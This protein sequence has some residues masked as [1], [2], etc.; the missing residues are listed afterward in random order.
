MLVEL[1]NR[2]HSAQSDD[3]FKVVADGFAMVT[4][5]FG[6]SLH[7]MVTHRYGSFVIRRFLSI[8]CG[9]DVRS[10]VSKSD[11]IQE[12]PSRTGGLAGKLQ[13]VDGN[14]GQQSVPYPELLE[15]ITE[16]VLSEDWTG[17]EMLALQC[18]SH[19]SPCLQ[20]LIRACSFDEGIT[21]RLVLQVLGASSIDSLPVEKLRSLLLDKSGSHLMEVI[22][23]VA[24]DDVYQKLTT[25]L[26]KGH[27]LPLAQHPCANFAVQAAIIALRK[28][29]QLKRMVEDLRPHI[30]SLLK[31]RRSGVV[32][33]LLATAV[34]LGAQ[35][36][37]LASLLWNAVGKNGN[38]PLEVLLTLDSHASLNKKNS[39]AKLST[40]GCAM[41]STIFSFPTSAMKQYS[42]ALSQLDPAQLTVIARDP[43]GCR[44]IESFMYNASTKKQNHVLDSLTRSW[45]EIALTGSGARFVECCFDIA[46]A[47][48]KEIIT[49]EL[50]SAQQKLLLTHR[51]PVLLQKCSV[52]AYKKGGDVKLEMR[53]GA[54][55][56]KN[57]FEELFAGI[58]EEGP[59]EKRIKHNNE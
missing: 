33:A 55:A 24:P 52:L 10:G 40:L 44:V 25:A 45:G 32:A 36:E 3:D 7:D 38:H 34:K 16:V 42:D 1:S 46:D 43:G 59:Q 37:E 35:E 21:K 48:R 53:R 23:A 13:K 28:P 14:V 18:D 39:G 19:A 50:A 29:A 49:S 27:L 31:G 17:P 58:D 8:L 11:G 30:G 47:S 15:E 22:F 51:G 2:A 5:I 12:K 4:G 20:S 57:E 9:K 26:F 6:A 41:L 56:S 54:A